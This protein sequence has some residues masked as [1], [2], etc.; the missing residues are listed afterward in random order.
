MGTE[1]PEAAEKKEEE[2]ESTSAGLDG[3]ISLF[4]QETKVQAQGHP[5]LNVD[6]C[7][8]NLVP[9]TMAA[10]E[11]VRTFGVGPSEALLGVGVYGLGPIG[12]RKKV[13]DCNEIFV[14]GTLHKRKGEEKVLTKKP[15]IR[16]DVPAPDGVDRR[17]MK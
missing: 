8:F 2:E 16:P 5:I 12:G 9:G 13:E 17:S 14:Q 10:L 7:S 11:K 4:R 15:K 1:E 3:A 6:V